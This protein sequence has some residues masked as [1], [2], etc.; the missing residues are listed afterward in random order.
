M[1]SP[2]SCC[3]ASSSSRSSSTPSSATASTTCPPA[4]SPRRTPGFVALVPV[5]IFNYV[6]FE[7]RSSAAEEM[8]NP[9]RDI[10]LSVLRSGLAAFVLYG[11]SIAA[12]G[13]AG[14]CRTAGDQLVGV[15]RCRQG[16]DGIACGTG[17]R[18]HPGEGRAYGV[19]VG[20]AKRHPARLRLVCEAGEQPP[21]LQGEVP[22]L[23]HQFHRARRE[24]APAEQQFT[25]C[26]DQAQAVGPEQPGAVRDHLTGRRPLLGRP[27]RR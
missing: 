20:E 27:R 24:L 14:S 4:A 6:G 12:D 2:G 22:A 19:L 10:P 21:D 26:V 16:F 25:V 18:A 13:T 17:G 23:P 1:P 15:C 3:C 8:R 9:R 11:G 5:L 7:L